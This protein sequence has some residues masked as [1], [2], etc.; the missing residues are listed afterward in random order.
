MHPPTP[1]LIA[2]ALAGLFLLG[3]GCDSQ[4]F[5]VTVLG[6]SHSDLD[7]VPPHDWQ[8]WAPETWIINEHATR[9]WHCD[10]IVE[11]ALDATVEDPTALDGE[12]MV[13][14]CGTN[15]TASGWNLAATMSWI[16]VA[17]EEGLARDMAVVVVAPPPAISDLQI[18]AS[19][20]NYRLMSLRAEIYD[21]QQS[22]DFEVA[23]VWQAILSQEDIEL[24]FTGDGLHLS[25]GGRNVAFQAISA[26]VTQARAP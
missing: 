20:R 18:P 19:L 17:V 22:F 16:Q 4:P 25:L 11:A 8:I 10:Q 9:S 15:D 7:R 21:L 12:V 5:V 6:D 24:Q 1:S 23:D 2:A 3:S 14:F 13:V 26:A